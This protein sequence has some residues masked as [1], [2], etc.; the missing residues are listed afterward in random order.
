MR[1]GH[2]R[3]STQTN[4]DFVERSLSHGHQC[5]TVG[6]MEPKTVSNRVVGRP[7]EKPKERDEPYSTSDVAWKKETNFRKKKDTTHHKKNSFLDC[8]LSL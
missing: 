2:G 5:E 7:R 8:D 1:I 3:Y 6:E 4:L